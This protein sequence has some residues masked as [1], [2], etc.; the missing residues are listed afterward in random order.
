MVESIMNAEMH[1]AVE[2]RRG[3][4]AIVEYA[5]QKAKAG[6]TKCP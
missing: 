1:D 5:V 4:D 2:S 6:K 3:S